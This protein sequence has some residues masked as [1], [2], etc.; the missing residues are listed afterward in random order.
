MQQQ[1]PNTLEMRLVDLGCIG[2][3]RHIAFHNAV[4]RRRE[5]A[6]E[7]HKLQPDS[8][9]EVECLRVGAILDIFK[10]LP[11]DI[12]VNLL[13]T[14]GE[15]RTHDV[16]VAQ[17]NA[18]Q[19]RDSCA[20]QQVDEERLYGIVAVMCRGNK[21]EAYGLSLAFKETIA[22]FACSLFD[23]EF[24]FQRVLM[25]VE[26]CHIAGHAV[27]L[28]QTT[29]KGLVAVTVARTQMKIAMCDGKRY[30]SVSNKVA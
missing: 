6:Q 29:H 5:L 19:P 25:G 20:T 24:V 15:Q 7:R 12:I 13:A 27:V 2:Q 26:L 17:R 21:L 18:V 22:Q 16:A 30:F 11:A 3:T 23:G 4:E 1:R 8:V 28:G 14:K 10:A 9:A